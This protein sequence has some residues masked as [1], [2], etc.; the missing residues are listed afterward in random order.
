MVPS[1]PGDSV[2]YTQ[3]NALKTPQLQTWISIGGGDFS[4]PG[5]LTFNTWSDMVG[6]AENRAAFIASLVT[7]MDSWGFQGVDL[8]WEYPTIAAKGGRPSDTA[9]LCNL[10]VSECGNPKFPS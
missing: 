10:L 7:F 5:T 1:D 3:F 8:D 6:T 2:L 9:N 4:D